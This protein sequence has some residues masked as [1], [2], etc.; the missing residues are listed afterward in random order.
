MC[1][2]AGAVLAAC[3]TT[4]TTT[5]LRVTGLPATSISVP[6]SSVGCTTN[7]WC[8]ALGTSNLGVSPTS[9]AEFRSANGQWKGLAAPSTDSSTYVQTSSCWSNGC[10][11]VGSQSSGDLVWRY[12]AG[13]RALT[14][15]TPPRGATG[16]EA[17]SC[18]ALMTCAILDSMR[19]GPR[20]STTDDGGATWS[21]PV[22]L[23]VSS[24]DTVTS[25]SCS[26]ALQCMASFLNSSNGIAVYVTNDGGVTWAPRVTFTTSPWISLT[27][28]HCVGRKC[29]GL[30][31][32]SSGWRVVRT[33]NFGHSWKKVSSL[34]SSVPTLACAAHDRCMVGGTL[35]MS[36]PWLATVVA[37]SLTTVKLQYVPTSIADVACGSK[38]CAAI[39]VTTVMTLRP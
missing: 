8:V 28:L 17:V 9:V 2:V 10:L 27:S 12:I 38:I 21:S 5:S 14:V 4:T 19:S 22:T 26:S 35:N 30:A 24:N 18:Y 23:G 11:F 36:S 39:G 32:L 33:T 34:P 13:T 37:G 6:L 16:I 3:A 7:N 29:L 20:F 1:A 25:L 15:A 31:K